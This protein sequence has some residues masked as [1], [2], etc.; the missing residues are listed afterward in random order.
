R[1][2][3][4]LLFK[5][6]RRSLYLTRKMTGLIIVAIFIFSSIPISYAHNNIDEGI[7][8]KS[9]N[10]IANNENE[11]NEELENNNNS[12]EDIESEEREENIEN[13]EREENIENEVDLDEG[14]SSNNENVTD[15]KVSQNEESEDINIL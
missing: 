8:E 13:E 4:F 2:Y 15:N 12:I 1:V 6:K 3:K 11:S 7:E 14:N 9:I 5:V 10:E